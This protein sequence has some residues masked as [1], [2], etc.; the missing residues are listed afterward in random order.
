MSA[1]DTVSR[2]IKLAGD[3][4]KIARAIRGEQQ[5]STLAR[6]DTDG[7]RLPIVYGTNDFFLTADGAWVGSQLSRRDRREH[8]EWRFLASDTRKQRYRSALR[9]FNATFPAG[10]PN[11]GHI[12]VTHKV[13]SAQEWARRMLE[14]HPKATPALSSLLQE[15]VRGL[16]GGEHYE[17][18]AWLFTRIG[19]R[20]GGPGLEGQFQRLVNFAL[21]GMGVDL[22]APTD[23]EADFWTEEAA[24]VNTRLGSGHPGPIPIPRRDVEWVVRHQESPAMPTP[25]LHPADPAPWGAGVWRTTMSSWTRE[26]RLPG[27]GKTRYPAVRFV[28]PTSVEPTYAVFLPVSKIPSRMHFATNWADTSNLP[29]AVDFSCHFERLDPDKS[30]KR[31]QKAIHTANSQAAED[32]EAG[33]DSDDKISM[34]KEGLREAKAQSE[35]GDM[36]TLR[37]QAVFSVFDTDPD[38]LREKV[39]QLIEYYRGPGL[40]MTL[41]V[42]A[43]DQRELFYSS[44]PGSLVLVDSWMHTTSPAY[45]AN[46]GVWLNEQVGDIGHEVGFHQG[47]VVTPSGGSAAPFYFDLLNLAR[48]GAPSEVCVAASG[49]GKTVSRGLKCVWEHALA[50]ITQTVWDPKRDFRSLYDYAAQ[51]MLDPAKVRL[52]DL[53]N[54][55]LSISLDLYAMAEHGDE[56]GFDERA[57]TVADGLATL[58]TLNI[59]DS[60]LT[61]SFLQRLVRR[62][63]EEAAQA[64]V[65]PS[66]QLTLEMAEQMWQEPLQPQDDQDLGARHAQRDQA[67][68]ETV[69]TTLSQIKTTANGGLLFRD[70]ELASAL[71]LREGDLLIF[72]ADLDT[73][74]RNEAPTK[75]SQCV[76]L[77]IAG[78]MTDFIRSLAFR[79]PDEMPIVLTFDEWHAIKSTGRADALLKWLRRIGRSKRIAVRQ[80]SQ[81]PVEFDDDSFAVSWIGGAETR[82]DAIKMCQMAKIEES[83]ENVQLLLS[84]GQNKDVKGRMIFTDQSGVAQLT[85][86]TFVDD[87]LLDLFETNPDRKAQIHKI[88]AGETA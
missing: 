83:E 33:L 67:M 6:G 23:A 71:T 63:M 86:T 39:T 29:F 38:R 7:H 4:Y 62:T 43:D 51:L 36:S 28:G 70:P 45:L 75:L 74:E 69:A 18:D 46:S 1:L 24:I 35:M 66:M 19:D 25:D 31:L 15:Q 17:R 41:E 49:D 32:A 73:P 47:H 53:R 10:E 3:R 22:S 78:A 88:L 61:R 59:A 9:W 8:R 81:Y 44:L 16:D 14:K 2:N 50:G 85:Q 82:R 77:V 52:I 27:K 87:M 80:M 40:E 60:D 42:P 26:V 48:K 11:S 56:D 58:C 13:Y 65:P 64:G 72:I 55:N 21:S 76:D 54:H 79:F 20:Q 37:W 12:V 57:A 84:M 5:L 68:A 34:Q 30:S